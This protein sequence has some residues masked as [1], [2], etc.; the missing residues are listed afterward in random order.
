MTCGFVL[1]GNLRSYAGSISNPAW[2]TDFMIS[3]GMGF[4]PST[5]RIFSELFVS[6]LHLLTLASAS[7]KGVT[8]RTQLAQ[9]M[10]VLNFRV[11]IR[12]TVGAAVA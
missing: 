12:V 4:S 9:L 7:R 10:L 1:W 2:A 5:V 8:A 11:D 3:S 6:T